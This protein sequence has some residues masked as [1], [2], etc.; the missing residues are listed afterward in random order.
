MRPMKR[1]LYSCAGLAWASG[2]CFG[3]M[4]IWNYETTAGTAA[5]A[6]E[7]LPNEGPVSKTESRP[8]LILLLHP[9]CPCSRATVGELAH[10]MAMCDGKLAATVLMLRPTGKPDGWEQTGLWQS[11]AAIPGVTIITDKDGAE[12]RRFRGA[13]SGQAFLYASDG[14]LL[15]A[16]GITPSRG[17]SGD[18][19]G[20]AAIE[21]LILG[22]K[23][24]TT[25]SV[26]NAP[27]FGCPLFDAST[28]CRN[29][30]MTTCPK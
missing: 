27:V 19:A 2:T 23:T 16:G 10:L 17:H 9:H 11:A 6:P 7:I 26:A 21:S 28:A 13:T 4:R 18:N 29:E 3:L 24:A 20:R 5:H 15:F 1:L 8:T 22:S 12:S 30:G 25:E 14:R